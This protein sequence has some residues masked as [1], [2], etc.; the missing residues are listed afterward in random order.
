MDRA[1]IREIFMAHGFTVKEG[2]TDLKEYVYEAAEALLTEQGKQHDKLVEHL[3]TA[4]DASVKVS[5]SLTTILA[6]IQE[7]LE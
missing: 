3:A 4:V 1:K 7:I 2:Q 6:E 5:A